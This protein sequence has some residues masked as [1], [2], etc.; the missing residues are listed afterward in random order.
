[1]LRVLRVISVF[2][3]SIGLIILT[4]PAQVALAATITVDD[5]GP[6]DFSTIQDAVDFASSGDTITIM[7]G[8]YNEWV[9]VDKTL[10]IEGYDRDT[11]ILQGLVTSALSGIDIQDTDGVSISNLTIMEYRIGISLS[12]AD[13]TSVTNTRIM[14]NRGS[15]IT[16]YCAIETQDS[17]YNTF[18]GNIISNNEF[19]IFLRNGSDTIV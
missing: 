16:D 15:I 14:D 6:A 10:T 3:V 4:V 13:N 18:T 7:P 1:M 2:L 12:N 9:T 8:T 19:G 5:D 11:T 17:D